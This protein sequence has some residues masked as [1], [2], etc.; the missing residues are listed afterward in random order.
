[1]IRAPNLLLVLACLAFM[2]M[3]VGDAHLH[4]CLDG[5]ESASAVHLVDAGIHHAEAG[6]DTQAEMHGD[7]PHHD[8][9]DTELS[10]DVILKSSL[11]DLPVLAGVLFALALLFQ[12]FRAPCPPRLPTPALAGAPSFLRPPLRGP[13]RFS[14]A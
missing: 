11:L 5:A 10:A 8:D 13:P 6:A 12:G 4:R 14:F 7:A 1:M 3:R 9:V 2:L